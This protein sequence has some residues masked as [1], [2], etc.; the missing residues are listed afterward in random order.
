MAAKTVPPDRHKGNPKKTDGSSRG[1]KNK[2]NIAKP[3]TIIFILLV[4]LILAGAASAA[5]LVAYYLRDCPALDVDLLKTVE[6]SILYDNLGN[7]VTALHAEQN[8]LYIPLSEIPDHMQKAVIALEDERFEKHFGFDIIGF[9]R[10]LYVNLRTKSFSQ[11]ATTLT[12]ELVQHSYLTQEK[13]IKRKVQEIWL[14]VQLEQ[15][16][17]KDEILEMYLNRMYFGNGAYG[18]ETAS[19]T[20]FNKSV[21]E[22]TIAE[23]ALL[24]ALLRAPEYYNPF[25]NKEEAEARAKLALNNMKRLGFISEAEYEAAVNKHIVYA[26]PPNPEYPYPYFVDYV[27]HHELIEIL[28]AMPE[29]GNKDEA[30]NAIYNGGLRIYTTLDTELQSHVEAVMN[31]AE[32]YPTTIYINMEKLWEAFLAN[33]GEL[34]ADYPDAYIDE[35]NGVPQPQAALVLADP[36]TGAIMALGGGRAYGPNN[37]NLRFL[38]ERQPGSAIKPLIAYA[39]AFEE[40]TLAGAGATLDD[41]PMIVE[42]NPTWYPENYSGAFQGLVTVRTGLSHSLNIPAVRTYLAVGPEKGAEYA[43]RMGLST[44]NPAEAQP[45][46]T[47]GACEVT[48][49]DM[50]QAFA[51][52]ATD[53]LKI[54][55]YTVTRIEDREGYIIY[56]HKL[57]PEQVISEQTAYLI[58]SILQEVVRNTTARGL[59]SPRPM[60]AKTGTTDE[61][62]DAYLM[63]YTPNL[64]ASLWMGYD[65]KTM[66]RIVNGWNYTTSCLR[67]V[68]SKVYEKVPAE[69]FKPAPEGI[70]RVTVCSKS[71]LLPTDEC[72]DAEATRTDYFLANHVPRTE[73]DMH[74]ELEICEASGKIANEFC[75]R[76]QVDEEYFFNRPEFITTDGRWKRGA[77]RKPADASERAPDEVC[78]IHTEYTGTIKDFKAELVPEGIKLTWKYSGSEVEEFLLYREVDGSES[79]VTL[80]SDS[81][82]YTDS[83]VEP[84]KTY[85]YTLHAI[86]EKKG[87]VDPATVT[88]R[89]DPPPPEEYTIKVTSE[90]DNAGQFEVSGIG[91]VSSGTVISLPAGTPVTIK[92]EPI[93]GSGYV[94]DRWEGDVHGNPTQSTITLN[95]LNRNLNLIA[96]FKVEENGI[97]GSGGNTNSLP[98]FLSYLKQ[99]LD[100]RNEG[101]EGRSLLPGLWVPLWTFVR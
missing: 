36:Q 101:A 99:L 44:L 10:A 15:Q 63:A 72:R 57:N 20:Y 3:L 69:E 16:F 87:T 13:S 25:I 97:G 45:S 60:A 8:R 70:V 52:F 80:G 17:S 28:S 56:E 86:L 38:S 91:T 58:N 35:E 37:K 12:Q 41:S 46:W 7:E 5:G 42:A 74:I 73:C 4:V 53:G 55:Q 43:R 98:G 89:I 48:A 90:P 27:V 6:T 1:G 96:K 67:D 40:G 64:V 81:R 66:G 79:G 68:F 95:N 21:G 62:F 83:H 11:G 88:I 84:G 26:E 30:Y 54:D 93:P 47:L 82:S 61:F 29:Y 51:V 77:G 23:A 14:A 22:I 78:D 31:K 9:M 50:A 49:L 92:A 75:P 59:Q 65:I 19:Q 33:N 2:R 100:G 24:A 76:D 94:F 85:T 34:P 18:V 71:G 32:H 39:P